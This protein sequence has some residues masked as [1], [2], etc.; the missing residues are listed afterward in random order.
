MLECGAT[1]ETV[2]AIDPVDYAVISSGLIA[3]AREMGVK[4]VRSAYSTVVREAADASAALMDN[5]GNVVSQ[6][7]MIP[8]QLGSMNATFQ[9]CVALH[10]IA[11]L[12]EGDFYISNDPY[13]GAQH[14]PDVFMFQPVFFEGEVIGF[15]AS[16]AHH[17]EF[18]GS[19]V[20]ISTAASDI[21]QEGLRLPP[22]CWSFQRDW[23]GTG[24]LKRLIGTNIRVPQLTLGDFEA[25]F[26]AMGTGGNRL[27]ELA[28]KYGVATL[29]EAM[30]ELI[31]YSE[32]RMRAALAAVPDG[33]YHGCDAVDDDGITDD[34]L[35]VK[36][37]LTIEGDRA[38]LDFTGTAPQVSRNL[39]SPVSSTFSAAFTAIKAALTT[40]DIPFNE[41]MKR[42]V[43]MAVPYGSML[44]PKPPAP[45]RAR[46]E[47]CYRVFNAVM[48][49]LSQAVP[50]KAIACGYDTTTAL[51]MNNFDGD[52]YR[53]VLE[54]LGGGYGGS[55]AT[56]GVSGVG[57]PLANCTNT[58]VETLDTD[59]DFFRTHE[60]AYRTDSAGAGR[61]RGG[62][63]YRRR[64]EILKDGSALAMYADR[65]RLA[66][67]G[68]F[69]GH[70]GQCARC[71]VER[72]GAV[73]EVPSKGAMPLRKGDVVVI[74]TGGGAGY[75]DPAERDSDAIAA[76]V[77]DGWIS[78]DAARRDY[79]WGEAAE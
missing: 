32:R 71:R 60:Y 69:G 42:P 6:A 52:R 14:L 7:E 74:E 62:L 37:A 31:D 50:E 47:A 68:L 61:T 54:I 13:N 4:L 46:M 49:A 5:D 30:A 28:A 78:P 20:G 75:G 70:E 76:D 64:Y 25:Q 10:P 40:S 67:Q 33:T 11:T 9:A 66:P 63:G 1:K 44:N 26:A 24:R 2:M 55:V 8:M 3:A 23:E 21:Y 58:P 59:Y 79:G 34:P 65:F 43:T 39:N 35:P 18:G 22:S 27:R 38:H 72:D 16:V 56:D 15:G 51:S 12:K 29:Q 19:G 41:G 45:V 48:K 53:V 73:I 77:A 17:L 57:G 36:V